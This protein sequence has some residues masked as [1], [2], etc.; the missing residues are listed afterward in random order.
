MTTLEVGQ[1]ATLDDAAVTVRRAHSARGITYWPAP[2]MLVD[3][4][5][6]DLLDV[7]PPSRRP[8]HRR[9]ELTDTGA[10][11]RLG[12]H[13][14]TALRLQ[15]PREVL[16]NRDDPLPYH[17]DVTGP[18]EVVNV[19]VVFRDGIEGGECVL[20]ERGLAF[21]C[22][23]GWALAFDGEAIMHGVAPFTVTASPVADALAMQSVPYRISCVYYCE[24]S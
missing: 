5:R 24:R 17:F 23:D 3:A 1:A 7:M 18:G 15:P 11:A 6:T 4:A 9:F 13:C 10:V 12:H 8:T 19:M 16:V 20:P 2:T 22:D 14:A 21:A